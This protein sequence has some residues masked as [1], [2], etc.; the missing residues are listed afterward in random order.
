MLKSCH[1]KGYKDFFLLFCLRKHP[2]VLPK[3]YLTLEYPS[4]AF[5]YF[6]SQAGKTWEQFLFYSFY[7]L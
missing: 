6:C 4:A 2:I 3:I 5:S 7:T 1:P